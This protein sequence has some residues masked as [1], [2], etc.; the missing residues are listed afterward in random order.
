MSLNLNSSPYFDDF[1]SEKNYNRILF[2]PGV[3]VQARELTQ[4][5]TILQN[6]IASLGSFTLKAGAIISGCAE[7]QTQIDFVKIL[8]S[9]FSSVAISN[10]SLVSYIGDTVVGNT[11]G[12]TATI[13]DVK[14]GT[15]GGGA[16]RKTLYLTPFL[17]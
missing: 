1:D 5:Q 4:T 13:I 8:D 6:Q 16:V 12:I 3:A 15:E 2:K 11:T 10:S 14:T 7:T 9:D 17:F